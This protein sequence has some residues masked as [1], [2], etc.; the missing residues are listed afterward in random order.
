MAVAIVVLAS[1]VRAETAV[2]RQ[3]ELEPFSLLDG[4]TL[5]GQRLAFGFGAGFPY[6]QAMAAYNATEGLDVDLNVDSL[7]GVATVF[8][9]G[10]KLRLAHLDG[11][12][13]AVELQGQYALFRQPAASDGGPGSTGSRELTGLRNLDFE[14]QAILS[15]KGRW[16]SLFASAFYQGTFDFEPVS[17]GPLAGTPG[18][19]TYGSN[20]GVH[21][22]GEVIPTGLVHA[23]MILGLDFHLR[24]GDFVVLPVIELGFT[25]PT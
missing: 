8:S 3:T 4:D 2:R 13:F 16:G 5:G 15:F 17:Q 25:F 18:P 21:L 22:G 19:W 12:A 7:Y 20:L 14:P 24:T 6:V 23:Y 10:P 11:V 1:E 9:L